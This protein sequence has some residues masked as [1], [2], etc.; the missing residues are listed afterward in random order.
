MN[1]L[2]NRKTKCC[3]GFGKNKGKWERR[4]RVEN[5]HGRRKGVWEMNG[6]GWRDCVVSEVYVG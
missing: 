4:Y 3:T 1:E 2:N 5:S 6:D